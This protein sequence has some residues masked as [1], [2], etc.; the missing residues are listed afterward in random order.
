MFRLLAAIAALPFTLLAQSGATPGA[1]FYTAASIANAA[2]NTT[3]LYAPNTFISLYGSNLAY[4]T[5]QIGL[6]DIRGGML[7]T[8]LGTAGIHVLINQILADL[9]YLS[10]GQ[11]N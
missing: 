1:P 10:P 3:G 5:T 6:G 4:G 8:Q 11:V 7:P 2:S 9:F